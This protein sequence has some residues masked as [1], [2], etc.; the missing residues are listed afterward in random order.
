MRALAI[1]KPNIEPKST[2][3]YPT[4]PSSIGIKLYLNFKKDLT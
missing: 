4:Q 3:L 1:A 2:S